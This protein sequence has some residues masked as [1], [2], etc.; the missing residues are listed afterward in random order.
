MPHSMVSRIIRM[1]SR[2]N[3]TPHH[4]HYR[5]IKAHVGAKPAS[6]LFSIHLSFDLFLKTMIPN[7]P[8]LIMFVSLISV[9]LDNSNS[10]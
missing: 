1:L 8:V 4:Q 6:L 5:G 10:S 2:I 7:L 3:P 9:Q